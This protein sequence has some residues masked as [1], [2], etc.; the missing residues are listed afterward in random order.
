[1]IAESETVDKKDAEEEI[2]CHLFGDNGV[3][4][5]QLKEKH[6]RLIQE[7]RKAE[8]AGDQEAAGKLKEQI[9][10]IWKEIGTLKLR[11]S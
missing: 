1:M 5:M 9:N 3:R 10:A 4:D 7:V 2:E 11:N 6:L 8:A